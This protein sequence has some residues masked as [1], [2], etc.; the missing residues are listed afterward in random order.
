MADERN[1]RGFERPGS[2]TFAD[3]VL[4]DTS[5]ALVAVLAAVGDRLGLFRELAASGAATA[6]GISA[7]AGIREAYARQWLGAMACAG[8]LE[9][10]SQTERFRLPVEHV[11]VLAHEGG[12]QFFGG[13]YQMVLGLLRVVDQLL[14]AC[15][16]GG[17]L[18]QSAYPE[19]FWD[20]ME[21][22]TATWF[23]H[24]LVQEWIP[25]M[26]EIQTRLELGAQVA[27]I[28]CHR[29]RALI[30]LA[31]AFPNSRFVGYD[32]SAPAIARATENA[33][34]AGVWDRVEFVQRDPIQGL[35]G[36][37]DVVTMFETLHE[38][39]DPPRLLRAIRAALRPSGAYVCLEGSC[40]ERLEENRG[41]LGALLHAFSFLYC[42]S[43]PL[44][45]GEEGLGALGLPESR[46]RELCREAGFSSLRR[47]PV[48]TRFHSLY[49]IWP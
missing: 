21:R 26:P 1:T 49:E 32:L 39:P 36:A 10:D 14:S 29:G 17:G 22:F 8:Y 16:K 4:G 37:F 38:A 25:A 43:A 34:W 33:R 40:S 44:A 46:M 31:R 27:D 13:A 47:V 24:L 45:R 35:P 11:P 6:G 18:P 28:G 19:G 48:R 9:Y 30:R 41:S 7:R 3:R 23:D 20:G 5:A 12:P 15:R 2:G 42:L